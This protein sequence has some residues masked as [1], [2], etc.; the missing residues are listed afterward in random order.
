MEYDLASPHTTCG[1]PGRRS[2]RFGSQE[3]LSSNLIVL[4]RPTVHKVCLPR[5][6]LA[7]RAAAPSAAQFAAHQHRS[8]HQPSQQHSS[9]ARRAKAP[10][11]A[12]QLR[13][14]RKSPVC[15]AAALSA[16]SLAS[17]AAQLLAF[18]AAAPPTSL[19]P[20]TPRRSTVRCAEVRRATA[21]PA[22]A[23][24][25]ARPPRSSPASITAARSATQQP[26]LLSSYRAAP[27]P[28]GPPRPLS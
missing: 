17:P 26:R 16:G 1:Y 4:S 22:A 23:A 25:P 21:P 18:S 9:P 27:S 15:R 13:P 19:Q 24:R 11:A 10:P 14:Q 5:C 7:R 6:T 2:D 20:S 28:P 8:Q 3:S 12:P